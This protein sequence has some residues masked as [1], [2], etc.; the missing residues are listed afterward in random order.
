MS[1][2]QKRLQ[3]IVEYLQTHRVATAELLSAWLGVSA[4]TIYRDIQALVEQ[5][6]PVEGE[7]GVGYALSQRYRLP[8]MMFSRQELEALWLGTR[9]VAAWGDEALGQAARA[10]ME[11]IRAVIPPEMDRSLEETA[12]FAPDFKDY[13]AARRGPLA[14]VRRAMEE[15][16]KLRLSYTR[17]DGQAS[18][19]LVRP[20][21]LSFWGGMWML[22]AWCELRQDFRSFRLDRIERVTVTRYRFRVEPGRGV[23]DLWAALE[24]QQAQRD[25]Q[26]DAQPGARPEADQGAG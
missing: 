9:I 21:A 2:R 7:P 10:A 11:R 26:R 12:L 17:R 23:D 19:R 15:R 14:T 5:G 3:R 13:N 16:R 8:P 18:T 22:S 25:A 1:S 24:R 6:V 4:R 20:L